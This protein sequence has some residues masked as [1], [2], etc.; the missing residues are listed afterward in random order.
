[1][2]ERLLK[3]SVE[4][5][6][7]VVMLTVLAAGVGVWSVRQ[8]AIDAVPDI[9]SNQVQINTEYPA[10]S[11]TEI[12]TRVTYPV[13]TALAGIS[14]LKQTRSIS[15]NGFSQV[16]A[17]FDDGVDLYF[18]RQQVSERLASAREQLP[19]GAQPQMGPI[20]T[21][22]GE[23]YMW[24]VQ[25]EHPDGVGA[26][27]QDGQPGWQSD[28]SYLTVEGERLKSD[29]ERASYLRTVQDWIIRPQ[30]KGLKDVA[31][32]DAIGG[33]VKQY[34]VTPDPMKLVSYG[35]SFAQVIDALERNNVSIGAGYIERGGEALNVKVDG[36][37][38][39]VGQIGQIVVAVRQGTPITIAQVAQVGIGRE[40]RT[41]SATENGREVVV[42][43]AMM[44]IGGNSRTVAAAVD[45]KLAQVNGSLP[46]DVV[47]KPML[48]R[49]KL[50]DATIG[51]VRKN[52][53]EGAILVIVVLFVLL[54]NF[55]A[56]LLTSLAIPISM[57]LTATG[58]VQ[59]GISG[60][61]LSL[62]AIDFGLI[63][64]GSVILVENCLRR[65]AERQ[66][67]LGRKLTLRE[68]LDTVFVASKQVRSATAFGEAIIITVYLP[69]LALTGIEG[70]MF[71]PMAI[72]VIFA[73]TAA[74]VLSLTF[75]P[76]MLA[77]VMRG[78][79]KEKE[80]F[81]IRL[82]KWAYEPTVRLAVRWRWG[83]VGVAASAFVLSMALFARLGQEFVP[84][85]DEQDIAMHAI[86]I[87][88]T[89]ITQSTKMQ[90][91]V[92]K[93]ISAIPEVEFVFSKTGTAEMAAD[94][95]PANVSDA[96]VILKPK[97][98]WRAESQMQ[99]LIEQLEDESEPAHEDHQSGEHEDEHE[100]APLPEGHKGKLIRLIELTVGRL[101]GNNYEFTQPIQ[102]RFNE[103]ISGVRSDVAVKVY[104]DDFER[105]Q[106]SAVRIAKVLEGV[107]GA[108]DVKVE[109]TEGL[110]M[111]QVEIDRE[112]ISRH[113]LNVA[114]VQEVIAAAVGGQEAGQ[115]FEGDRRFDVVVRLPEGLRGDVSELA[116]LPIPLPTGDLRGV[117]QIA[118]S[119]DA[120]WRD[121]ERMGFVPL[122][123]VAKI[124]M[125]EGPNQ[126]SRE[127]GKR[128]VVVQANVRG[129]DIASFVNEAQSAIAAQAL[130]APGTWLDWGGQFEH[131]LEARQ[132]LAVVVPAC[133]F[134]IFVLLFSTF[135][136]A[137]YAV[138][139]FTC[140]PLALGGGVVALW[141]RGMP[142]SIS[143][144]VG[145]I[146]LSGVAVL[147]GLVMITFINQ[148]RQEGRSLEDSIV[149]GSLTRLRPVLM[150]AL[151]ASLGF[152]PMALAN[153]TGAEVQKPLATVVIGGIVSSTFLT[154]VVLPALYRI[155]HR[156]DD[157][158]PASAHNEH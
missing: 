73:L 77:L 5:R 63:V 26:A 129:R 147:N 140:V 11:P 138:M 29:V 120:A 90:M 86:R 153:G 119:A 112:A 100:H 12:E 117:A 102:M 25:F 18:A 10:L 21:G 76:A 30:L 134:L 87:P 114:D 66:H 116:N 72:T 52:L 152:V 3:F 68:R 40:L 142:F 33:Y 145:F 59:S 95:M 39:S 81:L 50:V 144:A 19:A 43:T 75:V 31:D 42:G 92:E 156:M 78:K 56:A 49:M 148:L 139:V 108:A 122:D 84:T 82:A 85:L 17:V 105:M 37:I 20:T 67:E 80:N 103:L 44:R 97:D 104:G 69:I 137:K 128:R 121:A 155:W 141:L 98:Q 151:V 58:M 38:E 136:S 4:H 34:H 36:R 154:L 7:L 46:P 158:V 110:P 96:F 93:A 149:A 143:A 70:K 57:L 14:G 101:A 55:R 89:G 124:R 83:V 71:R 23:V 91:E 130:P 15:R 127:N 41:G 123:A 150:T 8:V 13:E 9:T 61:L 64:D 106:Q 88:S 2:L 107:Q 125:V 27:K 126:V 60:N 48:N 135:N 47:A 24:A 157:N 146:A 74:F 6:F 32:I 22:L 65:L 99:E 113:G 45:Q 109:Q 131:L 132:R 111:L 115:V 62:G 79:I 133:F 28:G 35:L 54:G 118:S 94:P 1:M 16:T 51:T 53:V